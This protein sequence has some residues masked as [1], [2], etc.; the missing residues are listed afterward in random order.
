MPWLRSTKG[1][2]EAISSCCS[3]VQC[4]PKKR[5]SVADFTSVGRKSLRT[6]EPTENH[7]ESCKAFHPEQLATR[8][9]LLPIILNSPKQHL[10]LRTTT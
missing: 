3:L 4:R 5:C 2:P 6:A 7:G 10:D 1:R 9:E 8:Q